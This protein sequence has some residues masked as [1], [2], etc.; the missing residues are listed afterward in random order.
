MNWAKTQDS[1]PPAV[2]ISPTTH[3]PSRLLK[4]SLRLCR[5]VVPWVGDGVAMRGDDEICGSLFSYIDLAP[6]VTTAA[7]VVMPLPAPSS[8]SPAA[9][10]E[11][12]T[13]PAAAPGPDSLPAVLR[14]VGIPKPR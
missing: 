5:C 2:V 7:E 6:S 8:P 1:R 10:S 9:A 13:V 14:G 12:P 4:K 11:P 3:T